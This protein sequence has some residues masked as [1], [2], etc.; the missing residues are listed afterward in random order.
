MTRTYARIENAAVA[1]LLTTAAAPAELF[2]PALD[3]VDVT[4]QGVGVGWR[5]TEAGFAPSPAPPPA[6]PPSVAELKQQ[7]A[8]LA[9]QVAALS[10][11]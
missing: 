6:P 4:G 8:A 11:G 7:L 10:A 2:H 9:L 3:W 1:E 5:Q